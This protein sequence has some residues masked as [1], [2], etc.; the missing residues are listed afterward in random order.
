[1]KAMI[2]AAGLGTR[3]R[4]LTDERPKALVQIG[5][6]TLLEAAIRRLKRFGCREILVNI[7][8]L[9]EQI[10]SFLANHQDFGISIAVSDERDK[11]LDT[12]GGLKKAA[13]FFQDA[14]F[15]IHNVDVLSDI[16]LQALYAAHQQ[17][18]AIA[19]LAVRRRSSSRY[20]LFD[21]ANRLA[22]WRHAATGRER[23]CREVPE[24]VPLAF[25]GIYVLSPDIFRYMPGSEVFSIID[26]LL[27][28]G[29]DRQVMA[30]QHDDSLWLDV[31]KPAA[32][33]QAQE[34]IKGI[35]LE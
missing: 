22:G 27:E 35:P 13:W 29:R 5:G 3:L 24:Y 6:M 16:D 20:L 18:G 14:P 8:H 7:H 12:G 33:P 30:F 1:M 11:L 32:L 25:S 19:T 23:I 9:G 34:L 17:S 31:G 28:A 15:I 10:V 4:P 26:V 2:F 21:T